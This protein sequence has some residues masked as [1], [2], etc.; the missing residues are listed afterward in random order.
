MWNNKSLAFKLNVHILAC[1]LAVAATV[2]LFNWHS[3]GKLLTDNTGENC[4]NLC[5]AAA[6]RIEQ[7]FIAAA[8]EADS[9][10]TAMELIPMN[11]N[12]ITSLINNTLKKSD[13]SV[14]GSAVAFEP[15]RFDP[16]REYFCPYLFKDGGNI[17]VTQ[18]GGKDYQ[19]F[20]WDWYQIPRELQQPVWSEPYFDDGGGNILMTTYSVPFYR[21]RDGRRILE[22]IVTI[23]ISLSKLQR[24]VDKMKLFNHGY[25]FLV[26]N[27]G[28]IITHPKVDL[29]MNHT[30]YTLAEERQ[31]PDLGHLADL[32]LSGQSGFIPYESIV[33]GGKYSLFYMPLKSTSWSLAI[34]IPEDELRAGAH[35]LATITLA[36]WAI[37]IAVIVAVICALSY[38]ITRPLKQL[39]RATEVVGKGQFHEPIP[40]LGGSIELTRMAHSFSA[41][42][43]ALISHIDNL[44]RTT[45]EKEKIESELKIARQIQLSIIPKIFPPFPER[46]EFNLFAILESAK[47]VGGDLYNFFFLDDNRL[48]F[49]IGDVSGKGIPASLFMAVTQTLLKANANKDFHPG[50]IITA[51]NVPLAQDNEMSM[52]V[53]YFLAIIDLRNGVIEYSNAG[54]N[55]PFILK[56]DRNV[57]KLSTLHGMPLGVIED[58]TYEN[59]RLTLK[60]GDAIV[61]YTDGVT[62]AMNRDNHEFG[63]PALMKILQDNVDAP[64]RQV[65]EHIMGG[66]KV[67]TGGHEQ[68]DDI[69]ILALRYNGTV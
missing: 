36:M 12:T 66:V 6:N 23:D 38:S 15:Y 28:R 33:H 21:E 14:F 8:K 29:I 51:M 48:C 67:H 52:F 49:A 1:V 18:L 37:G 46:K 53:T 32:M 69:T 10:A 45:A 35:R 60:P 50:E 47:A 27:S 5:E 59:S 58:V 57:E 24:I 65:I 43:Q 19:Y 11:E 2:I 44:K 39:T 25:G 62:E 31:R 13:D 4:R 30:L 20:N 7:T 41:M 63:E 56:H 34:A 54:H 40:D 16:K 64:A 9:M 26:S 3:T 68:S 61:L 17:K 55:P 22:G 42:Q